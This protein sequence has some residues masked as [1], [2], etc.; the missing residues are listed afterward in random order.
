M[1]TRP[2][3]NELFRFSEIAYDVGLIFGSTTDQG[4]DRAKRCINRAAI[5]MTSRGKRWNWLRVKDSVLT[6]LGEEEYSLP[7]DFRKE[8][9]FWIQGSNRQKLDRISSRRARELAPDQTIASGVPRLYDFN[10]VDSSGCRILTLYPNPSASG[11][12]VFFRYSR[13]V[14][15]IRDDAKDVRA[16]WGMPP[17]VIEALT[18]KAS[19]L[20][21]QGVNSARYFQMNKEADTLIQELYD[22][23]QSHPDATYQAEMI[24]STDGR[25][26]GDPA[27][28]SNYSR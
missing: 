1:T 20:A 6:T 2:E 11:I 26:D 17:D 28:P 14:M 21:I 3:V 24:G 4:L 25:N 16:T 5:A 15:P 19:A 8:E 23:D 7:E 12:E 18:Q 22:D 9:M 13:H 10:G 27:F